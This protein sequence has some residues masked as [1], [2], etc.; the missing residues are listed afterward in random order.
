[1]KFKSEKSALVALV[2]FS[3]TAVIV[4]VLITEIIYHSGK[5][6]LMPLLLMIPV[7]FL[8]WLWFGTGYEIADGVFHYRSGPFSGNIL[9]GSIREIR[10]SNSLSFAGIKPALSTSGLVIFYNKYDELFI[11]PEDKKTFIEELQRY[12]PSIKLNFEPNA[13][14]GSET[15]N[16]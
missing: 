13:G 5:D 11:S 2:I 6:I 12:N 15:A 14:N 9:I 3:I 4:T 1:M 10:K 8:L 16:A 7:G